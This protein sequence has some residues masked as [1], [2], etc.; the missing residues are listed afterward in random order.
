VGATVCRI[1]D[2]FAYNGDFTVVKGRE[3]FH[4]GELA[5]PPDPNYVDGAYRTVFG[6]SVAHNGKIYAATNENVAL[7]IRRLTGLRKP[8]IEG[9]H[10]QLFDNQT[11]ILK[12]DEL[13]TFFNRVS[14]MYFSHLSP[15]KSV[16]EECVEHHAD[17][18]PKQRLRVEA[19]REMTENGWIGDPDHLWIR[20]AVWKMKR[21]EWAKP[22]KKP[23]MIVDLKTPASLL[24]FRLMEAL[25]RAQS[26]E[27]LEINGG[28][29]HFCKS[30]DPFEMQ[31]IFE[32]L[33]NPTKRFYFVYFSDDACFA[34]HTPEGIKRYNLD[35][36][37]CDASHSPALFEL[38]V[39]L[40]PSEQRHDVQRL[41]D[42]CQAPLKIIATQNPKMQV[43]IKPT[44]PMLYSGSTITTAINNLANILIAHALSKLTEFSAM[45][46]ERAAASVGYI[47]T[48]TEP[49]ENYHDL[50][51]LKHS[52]VFDAD[53]LI[54]PMLNLGVLLRSSGVCHG[55]LP[56]RGPLRPRAEAF[57]RGLLQ[58][59]YPK[60]DL[61]WLQQTPGPVLKLPYMTQLEIDYKLVSRPDYPRF[62]PQTSSIM[63]RYR[64]DDADLAE[65]HQFGAAGFGDCFRGRAFD[66][67]LAKDYELSTTTYEVIE[68][69]RAFCDSH[70]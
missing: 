39:R 1:N 19:F 70:C 13:T 45:S 46:I 26:R 8:K 14:N 66:K 59:M 35:I 33:H 22:G 68:S 37:S 17:P 60:T 69:N 41:V 50:Q 28:L 15:V 12:T 56:G 34:V 2:D 32:E 23:R 51:F 29:V 21:L 18:H 9:L 31:H 38:L 61:P 54:R 27:D 30:P 63:Q 48:G 3:F 47:V 10:Q 11:N 25:K 58:G 62:T 64:L 4:N 5:F 52:P 42:Q 55:D 53:E 6:P 49:L 67:I 16:E 65:L 7:A 40:F 43:V 24:G 57:Q 44:R 36:S 20:R